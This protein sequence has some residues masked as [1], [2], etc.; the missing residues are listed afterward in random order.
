MMGATPIDDVETNDNGDNNNN[1]DPLRSVDLDDLDNGY[2]DGAARKQFYLNKLKQLK[3][4]KISDVSY[5][6]LLVFV[7]SIVLLIA[8]TTWEGQGKQNKGYALSIPSLSMVLS[9]L[10]FLTAQYREELYKNNGKYLTHLLFTWNFIGASYLTF[11]DPFTTTGNGYFAAWSTVAA[12]AMAMGISAEA[13]KDRIKGLGSLMGSL[14]SSIILILSLLEHV[15]ASANPDTLG[16][17]IYAMIV[18]C[19]T[20]VLIAGIMW[21]KRNGGY[22]QTDPAKRLQFDTTKFGILAL[23]AFLW[24]VS[25][26]HVT[27]HGPFVTTGNGY[28][29]A[30]AGSACVAFAAY[31][32][33]NEIGITTEEIVEEG[34]GSAPPTTPTTVLSDDV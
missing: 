16:A 5:P 9:L 27:F 29:S 19:F 18:S 15:G 32:A 6:L 31:N 33:K 4:T 13:F 23:F 26:C 14:G 11:N 22:V 34:S 7:S 28:F 20:V 21:L 17:A 2:N 1:V 25:A 30:W 8:V 12:S 24:F 10:G 3:S